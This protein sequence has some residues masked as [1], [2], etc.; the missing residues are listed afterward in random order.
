MAKICV[1]GTTSWGMTLAILLA[2]RGTEV[3]LWART[4]EEAE[5]LRSK[6][7]DHHVMGNTAFPSS[8]SV[9]SSVKEAMSLRAPS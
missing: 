3:K 8:L 5:K 6:G 4:E 2:R 9:T 7:P 1:I